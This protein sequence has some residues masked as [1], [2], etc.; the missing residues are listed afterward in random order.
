M[1]IC[2]FVRKKGLQ[3]CNPFVFLSLYIVEQNNKEN[4]ITR[5]KKIS[6]RFNA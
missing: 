3:N 6:T 4:D 2:L 1:F 5:N